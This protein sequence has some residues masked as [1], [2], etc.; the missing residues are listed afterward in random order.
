M[1]A[2]YRRRSAFSTGGVLVFI[3]AV[4]ATI[5]QRFISDLREER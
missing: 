1:K 4:A 2:L 3:R 5:P